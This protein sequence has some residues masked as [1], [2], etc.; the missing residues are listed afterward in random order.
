MD[1]IAVILLKSNPRILTHQNRGLIYSLK[2]KADVDSTKIVYHSAKL[3]KQGGPR[4]TSG[5][6]E[7]KMA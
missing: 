4:N 5:R 3:I 7:T 2:T 1:N 6:D